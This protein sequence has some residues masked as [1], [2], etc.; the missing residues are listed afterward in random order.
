MMPSTSDPSL[1]DVSQNI[2]LWNIYRLVKQRHQRAKSVCQKQAAYEA[3][4][5]MKETRDM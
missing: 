1:K 2:D 5:A 3:L 4:A